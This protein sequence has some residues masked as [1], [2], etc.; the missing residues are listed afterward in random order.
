[1]ATL[2]TAH[3]IR[4]HPTPEQVAY[5]KRAAGTRR[6]VYNWGLAEWNRQYAAYKEEQATIPEAE[7]KLKPPTAMD[8][9]QQFNAIRAKEF[10]WT[11]EV[12]KCACEGAFFDLGDAFKRCFAGQTQ[13]P[14]FKKKGKSHE[15]FYLSNDKFTIGSHWISIPGLGT[16]ITTHR[17]YVTGQPTKGIQKVRR[18]LGTVNLAEKLRFVDDAAPLPTKKRNARKQVRCQAVRIVGATVSA[19]AGWWYVSLHVQVQVA[20]PPKQEAIVGI[21]A[22]LKTT[23][24]V[25]NGRVLENQKPLKSH[26]TKLG[27]LQRALSRCQK[28]KDEDTGH[29]IYSQNYQKR[30]VKVARKHKQI[31]D[32]RAD[33]QH[34]FTTEIAR[35]CGVVGIEDLHIKGMLKNHRKAR[36]T[37]DAAMGQLVHLLRTTVAAAGGIVFIAERWF[38]STKKCSQCG[39]KKKRMPEKHRT[40]ICLQC[41][42]VID[43]DL[44]AA[45]N[46]EAFARE[47]L[48]QLP[49]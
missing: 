35:T 34:K 25:S 47:M 6:F 40:Y 13:H 41:G 8:L 17:E 42:L 4:M 12:T 43:R 45:R 37:A 9:K 15:S 46:L 21:D 18:K 36:A 3:K 48:R 11:Y 31:A 7:R 39:H 38:P 32:I 27:K 33:A 30:R 29:W 28:T 23:A 26:L 2:I 1:M 10:P 19:H 49:I 5:L 16:F 44:N 20:D 24:T 14:K 22:G